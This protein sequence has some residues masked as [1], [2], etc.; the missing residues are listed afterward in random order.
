MKAKGIF[1]VVLLIGVVFLWFFSTATQDAY[2]V[3]PEGVVHYPQERGPV[4][5]SRVLLSQD[6]YGT[7]YKLT[8][9]SQGTTVFAL[10]RL[11]IEQPESKQAR[12]AIVLLPGALVPKENED[13]SLGRELASLGFAV[14]ILDVRGVGETGGAL[15][16]TD[17]DFAV[18]REKKQPSQH[19]M[20][21]DA[22]RAFD[23]LMATPE[24]NASRILFAGES[25]G[26]RT[27]II[28]AALE[29]R[30]LGVLGISTAGYY[31]AQQQNADVN[32]FLKSINPDIYA[33]LIS[34]ARFVLINS[35]NDPAIPIDG[36]KATFALAEEPKLFF[37]VSCE[38]HGYCSE[39]NPAIEN[40]LE[41]ITKGPLGQVAEKPAFKLPI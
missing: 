40:A 19:L 1:A 4:S 11:P 7:V 38:K 36:A 26:G 22:L 14:L 27:A 24:V 20:F 25:N 3:S 32:R 41:F 29:K 15:S 17:A 16:S 6:D 33:P 39:M 21:Y 9:D 18:F 12:P 37:E 8:F 35:K 10:L 5:Y 2:V 23:V 34:P 30:S 13:V 31:F 28:A